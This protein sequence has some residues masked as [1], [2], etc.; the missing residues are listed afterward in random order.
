MKNLVEL[1]QVVSVIE[2]FP[3]DLHHF[4][5]E[6]PVCR[7]QSLA[8]VHFPDCQIILTYTLLLSLFDSREPVLAK[9]NI[10]LARTKCYV[11]WQSI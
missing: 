4:V 9:R 8:K 6:P 1:L 5:V 2:I 7:I 11:G 3:L 10:V